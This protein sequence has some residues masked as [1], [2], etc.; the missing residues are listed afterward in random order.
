MERS[1]LRVPLEIAT[2]AVSAEQHAQQHWALYHVMTLTRHRSVQSFRRYTRAADQA[3]AE[4]AFDEITGKL[5]AIAAPT[6]A[7]AEPGVI[8]QLQS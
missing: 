8:T 2:L 3:A 1:R 6:E 4:A 5:G 7:S